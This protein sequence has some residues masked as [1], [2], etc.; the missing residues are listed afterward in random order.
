MQSVK[1]RRP[2]LFQLTSI[3]I[4][5]CSLLNTHTLLMADY[6]SK[7]SRWIL[8]GRRKPPISIQ[9][10]MTY[11]RGKYPRPPHLKSLVKHPPPP[12][13]FSSIIP[14]LLQMKL[15][16]LIRAGGRRQRENVTK[17]R[18]AIAEICKNLQR[19]ITN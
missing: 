8:T 12:P 9:N 13:P 2:S 16:P 10:I 18:R 14:N 5:K 19:L 4:F 7:P 17:F 3:K 15:I 1:S 6:D 11:I